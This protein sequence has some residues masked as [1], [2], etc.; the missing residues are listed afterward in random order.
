VIERWSAHDP[1][2]K[3]FLKVVPAGTTSSFDTV[4][5]D[6]GL[7]RDRLGE[8]FVT[9]RHHVVFLTWQISHSYE[10]SCMTAINDR[11]NNGLGYRDPQRRV[12][13]IRILKQDERE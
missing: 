10:L 8:P 5:Q 9:G 1:T 6:L 2:D 12:Y 4:L 13:G 3:A 11:R 7:D